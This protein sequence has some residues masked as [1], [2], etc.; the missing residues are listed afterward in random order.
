MTDITLTIL[1]AG[2]GLLTVDLNGNI[3]IS[4]AFQERSG[5]VQIHQH[6]INY[7]EAT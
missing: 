1:Q 5:K 4:E 6:E 7:V 3:T 2:R